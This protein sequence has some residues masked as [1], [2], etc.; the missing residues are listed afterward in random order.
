MKVSLD[1]LP[2]STDEYWKEANINKHELQAPVLCEH[3]FVRMTGTEVRCH[4][5]HVGFIITPDID[6]KDGHL[7]KHGS[8]MI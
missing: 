4:K 7:Y 6:L 1:P 2:A 8:I 3:K 5:C